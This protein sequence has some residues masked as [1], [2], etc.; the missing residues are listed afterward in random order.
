MTPQNLRSFIVS[1]A[2]CSAPKFYFYTLLFLGCRNPKWVATG[3]IQGE[4]ALKCL[5]LSSCP[6]LLSCR[7][8]PEWTVDTPFLF[9]ASLV[10]LLLMDLQPSVT[11]T[12]HLAVFVGRTNTDLLCCSLMKRGH[13]RS[14]AARKCHVKYFWFC[15]FSRPSTTASRSLWPCTFRRL[16]GKTT[17]PT[18]ATLKISSGRPSAFFIMGILPLIRIKTKCSLCFMKHFYLL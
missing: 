2:C 3:V 15:F 9:S 18:W 8:E 12:Q 14:S 7:R 13:L 10:T 6:P 17:G 4:S 16:E 5:R 1:A 11:L